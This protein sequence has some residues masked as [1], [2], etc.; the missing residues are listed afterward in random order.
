MTSPLPG[1]GKTT[2]AANL[3]V[4]FAQAGRRT[5]LVDADLRRPAVH[6]IFGIADSAGLTGLVG[7]T[8]PDVAQALVTTDEPN[9]RVLPAGSPPPN[10]AE[11][12]GSKWFGSV[13][14]S[15]A[16]IADIVVLDSA[17]HGVIAD[18][19]VLAARADATIVVA[20]AGRTSR[21]A[22]RRSV[23][24]L[25]QTGA[26][27]VGV[28]LNGVRQP[29]GAAYAGYYVT[30]EPPSES[31]SSPPPPTSEPRPASRGRRRATGEA[32]AQ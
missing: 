30:G 8:D 3:A 2:V 14:A 32:A 21:A 16:G 19:A 18:A 26:R 24:G 17:P 5:V 20:R 6:E 4:A 15:L 12:L 10:P 1:D 13:L 27:V 23:Q 28:A 11:L 31:P 22:V 29:S 9:L 25:V 7:Q